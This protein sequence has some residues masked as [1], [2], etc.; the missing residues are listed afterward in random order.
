[1]ER[2]FH[3][4][5]LNKEFA[6]ENGAIFLGSSLRS[7]GEN[8]ATKSGNVVFIFYLYGPASPAQLFAFVDVLT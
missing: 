4:W 8:G 1:M 5:L 7:T 2:H 3:T 6:S